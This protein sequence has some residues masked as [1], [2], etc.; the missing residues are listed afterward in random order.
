MSAPEVNEA[1][2]LLVEGEEEGEEEVD[3]E[4]IENRDL[5]RGAGKS[6]HDAVM[7]IGAE[8]A[9]RAAA[10]AEEEAEEEEK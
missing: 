2:N 5:F 9:A 4:E 1:R 7:A 8:A 10:A 3:G 6:D